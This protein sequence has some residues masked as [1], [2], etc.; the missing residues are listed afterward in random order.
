[1]HYK[2]GREVRLGDWV[3]GISHNS[4][5]KTVVGYVVDKMP[6]QGNCNLKILRWRSEHFTEEGNP[7]EI[8]IGA[9]GHR[10]I[11]DYGDSKSFIRAD[12]G[13]RMV[14][15]ICEYGDLNAPYNKTEEYIH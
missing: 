1:M 4:E 12:D 11:E 6:K 2:N 9:Y 8:A 15:A 13:L 3:V 5:G 14:T 7:V 10:P